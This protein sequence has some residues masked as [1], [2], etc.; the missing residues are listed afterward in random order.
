GTGGGNAPPPHF[1]GQLQTPGRRGAHIEVVGRV[2]R[3]GRVGVLDEITEGLVEPPQPEA[4]G[5][6]DVLFQ[7][8]LPALRT[9]RPQLGAPAI[10]EAAAEALGEGGLPKGG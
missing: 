2:R 6:A 7:S 8:D 3:G 1:R 9:L 10:A 4:G 5:G